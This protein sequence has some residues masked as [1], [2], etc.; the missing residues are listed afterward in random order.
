[1]PAIVDKLTESETKIE[2]VL[3]AKFTEEQM[4]AYFLTTTIR[5]Q[6]QFDDTFIAG[7]YEDIFDKRPEK[8]AHDVNSYRP[9]RIC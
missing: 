3:L 8:K 9:I 7:W 5:S 4:C 1:M 2:K 6:Y